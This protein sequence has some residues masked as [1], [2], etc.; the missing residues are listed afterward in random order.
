MDEKQREEERK[1]AEIILGSKDRDE[2]KRRVCSMFD[3]WHVLRRKDPEK[4]EEFLE[5]VKIWDDVY[6]SLKGW[7]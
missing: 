5:R 7:P 6:Q 2:R 1:D 4:A 3:E